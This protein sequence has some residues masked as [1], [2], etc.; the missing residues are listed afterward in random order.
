ML[1]S[2]I[3]KGTM[4][5]AQQQTK[6]QLQCSGWPFC[7]Q[8]KFPNFFQLFAKAAEAS[9][10]LILTVSEWHIIN[11]STH[12]FHDCKSTT[13]SPVWSKYWSSG[14]SMFPFLDISNPGFLQLF[15]TIGHPDEQH[16]CTNCLANKIKHVGCVRRKSTMSARRDQSR[17]PAAV[18]AQ[19]HYSVGWLGKQVLVNARSN[20]LHRRQTT[21]IHPAMQRS[22][23]QASSSFTH[24]LDIHAV[25]SISSGADVQ[26]AS[27]C[28]A[29]I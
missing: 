17:S 27:M 11:F 24:K 18:S 25:R 20:L 26:N 3:Y 21:I 19:W 23:S 4:L 1:S 6:N 12:R 22:E 29:A 15:Q 13:Y 8:H 10:L 2:P 14:N 7:K 9:H 28:A 16:E 5:L